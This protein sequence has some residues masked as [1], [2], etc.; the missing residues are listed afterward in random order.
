MRT[1]GSAGHAGLWH[2]EIDEGLPPPI[3]DVE[4]GTRNR[5]AVSGQWE[6]SCRTEGAAR[7]QE[8]A[9]R[10]A[11]Q[12]RQ[13]DAVREQVIAVLRDH[14]DGMTLH[15]LGEEVDVRR[16]K[17]ARIIRKLVEDLVAV[18]CQVRRNTRYENGWKLV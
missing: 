8:H 17:I 2:V 15:W 3:D 18:A 10:E 4:D 7:S 16:P 12:M 13:D 11:E 9:A 14:P 5:R 1:G 6:V